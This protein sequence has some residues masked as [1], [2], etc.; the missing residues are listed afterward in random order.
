MLFRSLT[1]LAL[2]TLWGCGKDEVVVYQVEKSKPAPQA[3]SHGGHDHSGHVHRPYDF[4]LP[5]GWSEK[6]AGGMRLASFNVLV[7]G[8]TLDSSIVQLGSAAGDVPSN[9]N[10][11]R[12]QVGLADAKAEDIDASAVSG[13]SELGPYRYWKLQNPEK[14]SDGGILAAMFHL[15]G[16]VLFVKVSGSASQMDQAEAGFA[17]LCKSLRPHRH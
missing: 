6:E 14:A 9:V 13:S 15:P 5:E 7:D 10:R 2:V 3:A 16:A 1:C 11:W 4:D 12:G 17:Q 8:Q